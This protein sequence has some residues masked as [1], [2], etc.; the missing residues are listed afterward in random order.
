MP[1]KSTMVRR[2]VLAS[3]LGL[4]LLAADSSAFDGPL[5]GSSAPNAPA[6]PP[7]STTAS[8]SSDSRKPLKDYT[9]RKASV[10]RSAFPTGQAFSSGGYTPMGSVP[11]PVYATGQG[12]GTVPVS[13]YQ[14]GGSMYSGGM[15]ASGSAQSG[16]AGGLGQGAMGYGSSLGTT[17]AGPATGGAVGPFG[18]TTSGP[19]S[20][21]TNPGFTGLNGGSPFA[22]LDPNAPAV[23]GQETGGG[24]ESNLPNIIGD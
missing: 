13:P 6:T 7:A 16:V 24:D 22:P 23:A 12:A 18:A 21:A 8:D 4:G 17:G 19:G 1:T 14:S 3:A 15:P 11:N 2:Q 10:T 5:N 20:P 9:I